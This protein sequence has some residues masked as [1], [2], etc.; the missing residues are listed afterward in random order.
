MVVDIV[1]LESRFAC[2]LLLACL[3][4]WRLAARIYVRCVLVLRALCFVFWS[5][6]L[7]STV[8]VFGV[9]KTLVGSEEGE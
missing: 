1:D 4:A 9:P 7:L 2:L 5:L 6:D 8:L 3:L